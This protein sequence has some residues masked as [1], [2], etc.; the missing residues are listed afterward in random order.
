MKK[1]TLSIR[2]G[3]TKSLV[4]M[5]GRG[6]DSGHVSID[7]PLDDRPGHVLGNWWLNLSNAVK[8]RDFLNKW[9]ESQEST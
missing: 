1:L 4:A 5:E 6:A 2:S 8:L 3:Y 7:A 9:I